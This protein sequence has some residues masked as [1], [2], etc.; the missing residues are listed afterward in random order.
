MNACETKQL[1]VVW[2]SRTGTAR[3]MAEAAV[4][5]ALAVLEELGATEHVR[6]TSLQAAEATADHLLQ[7]DAFVFAAP[8][9]LASLSGEMKEFFDRNYYPVLDRLNGR[10]Y[11]LLVAAGSDGAGAVAQAERIATG[12]R[13]RCALPPVVVNTSAQTPEAILAQKPPLADADLEACRTTGGTLAA[14]LA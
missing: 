3:Q 4:Q 2:H 12:W 5:G 8:E 6:V 7:S 14:L 1:L 10:P 13:L 9:N 11:G